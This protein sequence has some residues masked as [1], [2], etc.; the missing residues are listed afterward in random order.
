MWSIS[1]IKTSERVEQPLTRAV[2]VVIHHRTNPFGRFGAVMDQSPIPTPLITLPISFA[3][4]TQ[5]GSCA[6]TA[7]ANF[8]RSLCT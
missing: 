2:A 8:A 7:S 3:C 5:R 1:P 4:A 6:F